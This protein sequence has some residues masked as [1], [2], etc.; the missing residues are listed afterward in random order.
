[1]NRLNK[2]FL[3]VMLLLVSIVWL[4]YRRMER[5]TKERDRFSMNTVQAGGGKDCLQE[6]RGGCEDEGN[7]IQ[8]RLHRTLQGNPRCEQRSANDNCADL[9]G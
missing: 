9:L 3:S 5:L 7:R 2:V 6:N 1:M 8:E 4:Q